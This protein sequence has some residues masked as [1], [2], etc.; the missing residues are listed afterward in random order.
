MVGAFLC[1]IFGG[2][3]ITNI[4]CSREVYD[5]S[6][7][8]DGDE[9]VEEREV[10]LECSNVSVSELHLELKVVTKLELVVLVR[11]KLI[12]EYGFDLSLKKKY[13]LFRIIFFL[14]QK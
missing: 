5:V 1:H 11:I 12:F 13:F 3:V 10:F 4:F 8:E 2:T 6:L 9:Y 14:T 7:G